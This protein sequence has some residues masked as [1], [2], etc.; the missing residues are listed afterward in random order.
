[1][2]RLVQTNNP[3]ATKNT[4]RALCICDHQQ[5]AYRRCGLLACKII[6]CRKPVRGAYKRPENRSYARRLFLC[7]LWQLDCWFEPVPLIAASPRWAL[8]GELLTDITQ[9][10]GSDLVSGPAKTADRVTSVNNHSIFA[11]GFAA[12]DNPWLKNSLRDAATFIICKTA[13]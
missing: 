11:C 8:R 2:T 12:L 1:M 10:A 6:F 5:S 9:H 13:R 7:F 4:K 3:I